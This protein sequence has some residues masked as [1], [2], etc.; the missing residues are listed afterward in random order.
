MSAFQARADARRSNGGRNAVVGIEKPHVLDVARVR[1]AIAPS[2]QPTVRLGQVPHARMTRPPPASPVDPSSTTS[3]VVAGGD[4]RQ[5]PSMASPRERPWLKQGMTTVTVGTCM[6]MSLETKP[7]ATGRPR[8]VQRM[9]LSGFGL[10][11]AHPDTA[12]S[13]NTTATRTSRRA[14]SRFLCTSCT[15]WRL[16]DAVPAGR[17]SGR[18]FVQAAPSAAGPTCEAQVAPRGGRPVAPRAGRELF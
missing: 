6:Q 2:R 12:T 18:T 8:L 9:F 11:R 13:R 3:D 14:A 5:T 15:A 10:M 4:W 17:L 16:R 1:T 7:A